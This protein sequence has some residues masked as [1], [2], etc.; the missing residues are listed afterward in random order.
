MSIKN[1]IVIIFCWGTLVACASKSVSVNPIEISNVVKLAPAK[2]ERITELL[3]FSDSFSNL[4]L[5]AQKKYFADTSQALVENKNDLTQRIK[6]AIMYA[7]PSS[8]LRDVTKAQNLLQD[9]LQENS[10]NPQEF[11]FTSLLYEYSVDN[12]KQTQKNKDDAKRLELVQQK[13]ESSQQRYETL[14]QKNTTLELKNAALEQ[15][16]HDLKNIEKSIIDRDT[17]P[18]IKP[19]SKP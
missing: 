13:Y 6:L 9:L 10:L 1:I 11:A 8:R 4:T 19:G 2:Q 12:V 14:Q 3:A 17:K 5:E 15:K 18:I 16:L 7:L